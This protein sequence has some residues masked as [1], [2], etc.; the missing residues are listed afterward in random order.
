MRF[1]SK[2]LFCTGAVGCQKFDQYIRMLCPGRFILVESVGPE[3][4]A[5]AAFKWYTWVLRALVCSIFAATYPTVHCIRKKIKN[6]QYCL[7]NH[8]ITK[9]PKSWLFCLCKKVVGLQESKVEYKNES[10]IYVWLVAFISDCIVLPLIFSSSAQWS[11][12]VTKP[13]RSFSNIETF[14]DFLNAFE[15]R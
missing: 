5:R 2:K 9:P 1:F 15:C 10:M 3:K 13:L 12:R 6:L 14:L 4:N 7:T 8:K 11:D